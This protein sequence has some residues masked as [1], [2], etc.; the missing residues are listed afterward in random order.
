MVG[1]EWDSCDWDVGDEWMVV[2]DGVFRWVVSNADKAVRIGRIHLPPTQR[3]VPWYWSN[4]IGPGC[5]R[6]LASLGLCRIRF[7][8]GIGP[9]AFDV[10]GRCSQ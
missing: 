6:G 8:H 4:L 1:G 10:L 5:S 2:G 7:G 9:L 3:L